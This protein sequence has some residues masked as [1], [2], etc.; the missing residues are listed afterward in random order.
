MGETHKKRRHTEKK[1]TPL[2][3]RTAGWYQRPLLYVL[4]HSYTYT[5]HV[6]QMCKCVMSSS[7]V[8]THPP[9]GVKQKQTKKTYEDE[10]KT[11]IL[12]E[13]HAYR[14]LPLALRTK[15]SAKRE[16][17]RDERTGTTTGRGTA[18]RSNASA[19]RNSTVMPVMRSVRPGQEKPRFSTHWSAS[20]K[21]EAARWCSTFA[22]RRHD[23]RSTLP[24]L[25]Q[26]Q[27]TTGKIETPLEF[28]TVDK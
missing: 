23:S 3:K 12:R 22:G 5:Q 19:R 13:H 21:N 18:K 17:K 25:P 6:F 26:K 9:Q 27:M 8:F 28:D 4:Q 24:A 11:T 2:F 14:T 20:Q 15:A 7:T 16:I 1:N 10:G